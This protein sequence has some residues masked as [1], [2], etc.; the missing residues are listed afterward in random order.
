MVEEEV[1]AEYGVLALQA[2]HSSAI[3]LDLGRPA[4]GTLMATGSG[5][6]TFRSGGFDHYARVRVEYWLGRPPELDDTWEEV[7]EGTAQ[8]DSTELRLQSATAWVSGNPI[9]LRHPGS[10]RLRGAATGRQAA[11]GLSQDEVGFPHGPERWLIQLW[12]TTA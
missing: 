2:H 5:G 8:V 3:A 12:P 11:A 4:R 10:Y 1:L 9:T 6:A 7:Q